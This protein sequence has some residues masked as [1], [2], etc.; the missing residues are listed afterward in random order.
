MLLPSLL[1]AVAIGLAIAWTLRPSFHGLRRELPLL[2][3][4]S[5]GLGLGASSLWFFLWL[6][7]FSPHRSAFIISEIGIL[8]VLIV[9]AYARARRST[10]LLPQ[11]I[12]EAH[13]RWRYLLA[14]ASVAAL[15]AAAIAFARYSAAAPHG[16]WDAW[17]AWNLRA[18]FLYLGGTHWTDVFSSLGTMPHRDYPLLLSASVARCWTYLKSDTPHGPIAIAFL[19]TFATAG[20]LF[21]SLALLRGR[22]QGLIAVTVL[23]ATPFFL[24]LGSSQYADVPL[25]FFFLSTIVL[26]CLHEHLAPEKGALALAGAMAGLAVWTKNEGALFLLCLLASHFAITARG[27]GWKSY[28]RELLPLMAGALPALV[29]VAFFKLHFAWHTEFVDPR[30]LFHRLRDF[31]RYRVV[32]SAIGSG[33][34]HFGAWPLSIPPLLFAYAL[35]L[36]PQKQEGRLAAKIG[37]ATVA[38]TACG[39]FFIYVTTQMALQWLLLTS[40]PRLCIQLYPGALFL[41]FLLFRTPEEALRRTPD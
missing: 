41:I 28:G 11:R 25:A 35:L 6:V 29:V 31:S 27:R 38:L 39:Y 33:L 3:F 17:G 34:F 5:V 1:I 22:S 40:L 21:C 19:F 16:S 15:V 37:L 32:A 4:L 30:G 14:L 20:V 9:L 12:S 10:P 13:S 26:L 36:G 24:V 2:A 23:L 18:R 7:I 8:A